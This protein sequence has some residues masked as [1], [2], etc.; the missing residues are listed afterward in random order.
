ML[1]LIFP[2]G[3]ED[4]R[5]LIHLRSL[6]VDSNN[7]Q[8]ISKNAFKYNNYLRF[9]SLNYNKLTE[10]KPGLFN[11]L[12]HLE[13]V[14]F[15]KNEIES[16]PDLM[17]SRIN[18]LHTVDLSNNRLSKLPEHAFANMT[19]YGIV[20]IILSHNELTS[21]QSSNFQNS[22]AV[23]ATLSSNPLHC[24]CIFLASFKRITADGYVTIDEPICSTPLPLRGLE[25]ESVAS[26]DV[27]CSLCSNGNKKNQTNQ[28]N[29]KNGGKC[30]IPNPVK[31]RFKCECQPGYEGELCEHLGV[32]VL[33]KACQNNKCSEYEKCVP[34]SAIEYNCTCNK[35]NAYGND[36]LGNNIFNAN[37]NC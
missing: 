1:F 18:G 6:L 17:V 19:N 28:V 36:P 15:H 23:Y 22:A 10:I 32:E 8:S 14:D 37:E 11:K 7:L 2:L 16:I 34:L 12:R 13:K 20:D 29:C 3:E 30:V 4:L 9:I 26:Q 33:K 24:D 21:L 35:N 31:A 27:G 5:Y 25:V